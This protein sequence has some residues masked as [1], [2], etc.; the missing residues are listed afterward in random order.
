MCL[1]GF[2]AAY[3]SVIEL[4]V[5]PVSAIL[6]LYL[7][8][9]WVQGPPALRSAGDLRAGGPVADA[10]APGLQPDRVRLAAGTWVTST[11][12]PRLRHVH[13]R[14]NPLGLMSPDWSNLGP[15]L[16]GRYRGLFVFAPILLLAM[17]GWV[18][19]MARRRWSLAI[20]SISWSLRSCW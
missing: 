7:L 14:D 19:L 5:A 12:R 6:G 17:P 20:V 2:L 10:R 15:L 3:A 1:A 4:Q 16:W 11:M 13:N 9:Q 18:V 8:V